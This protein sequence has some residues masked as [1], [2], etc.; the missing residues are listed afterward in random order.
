VTPENLAACEDKHDRIE[1]ASR[2][3]GSVILPMFR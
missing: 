3:Y 2:L 1:R